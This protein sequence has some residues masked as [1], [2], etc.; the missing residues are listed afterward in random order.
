MSDKP[1]FHSLNSKSLHSL[2][3]CPC[4]VLEPPRR[5]HEETRELRH[6]FAQTEETRDFGSKANQILANQRVIK[7]A[8]KG[9]LPRLHLFPRP[10]CYRHGKSDRYLTELPQADKPLVSA[11]VRADPSNEL[12]WPP[13]F[14]QVPTHQSTD[15]KSTDL[16]LVIPHFIWVV[17]WQGESG[18]WSNFAVWGLRPPNFV[19]D[20][21]HQAHDWYW[22]RGVRLLKD[23]IGYQTHVAPFQLL[24]KDILET[25]IWRCRPL[26]DTGESLDPD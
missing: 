11:L 7:E 17:D 23:P 26:L 12:P 1:G 6:H 15:S 2:D 14:W 16:K 13:W 9:H 19:F 25:R 20:E 5:P 4:S 3:H 24:H 22:S 18:H 21:L 10:R 8:R